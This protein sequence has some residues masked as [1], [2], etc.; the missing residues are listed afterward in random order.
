MSPT[1]VDAASSAEF[2]AAT[3]GAPNLRVL[4]WLPQNDLLGHPAVVA[5]LSHAGIHS[6]YEAIYHATPLVVVPLGADQFE[7][8]RWAAASAC[9]VP[10]L[11]VP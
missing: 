1:D 7:N 3:A 5:F 4:T 8:A 2:A 6:M 9:E 10:V 11:P